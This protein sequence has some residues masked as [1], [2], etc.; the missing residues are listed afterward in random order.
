MT[1][2]RKL[3][4]A[5][6]MRLTFCTKYFSFVSLRQDN[7]EFV[8]LWKGDFGLTLDVS[9]AHSWVVHHGKLR[10]EDLATKLQKIVTFHLQVVTVW[11]GFSWRAH[12]KP[13]MTIRIPVN[14]KTTHCNRVIDKRTVPQIVRKF[15]ALYRTSMFITVFTTAHHY[16][17]FLSV[18][19]P[20]HILTPHFFKVRFNIILLSTR[21]FFQL[22]SS[23]LLF[24][25]KF[26]KDFFFPPCVLHAQPSSS[27]IWSS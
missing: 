20:L 9:S 25:L 1:F 4:M 7:R 2:R 8:K 16:T 5:I 24:Q 23:F 27:L 10:L 19:N 21:R 22:V 11:T 6:H 18:M 3:C 14:M 12:L 17:I 26:S 13:M 15:A